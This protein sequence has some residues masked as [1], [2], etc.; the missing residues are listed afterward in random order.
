LLTGGAGFIGLHMCRR[1]LADGWDVVVV[2]NLSRHGADDDLAALLPHV[3]LV[4]HDLT[5]GLPP[6]VTGHFDAVLHLAAWVG[7]DRV[8]R[9][10][11]RV[12]RDNVVATAAVL[13][14]CAERPVDTVFLSSTS[15]VA[16]GAAALGLAGFPIGEDAPFAL[17]RPHAARTTYA[18]SKLVGE[19]LLLHRAGARVRIGRYYNVYGP[20]MGSNHVIPQFIERAVEGTDPFP[21]YGGTNRRAFCHVSDAVEA[22][23]RLVELPGDEPVIANIG[24]DRAELSMVELAGLVNRI[25][26][27]APRIEVHAAPPG[28]PE[29]RVPDLTRL[30]ALT[31]YESRTALADGVAETYQW[32]AERA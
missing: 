7:V 22:T 20:R 10:P 30:R 1:L 32:Y 31:G 2:D 19:S 25:A 8:G 4:E 12:L 23:V 5:A 9:E 27:T 26:G 29:R 14:W 15:E 13:D 16:D 24:D 17:A 3:H 28:S 11:F 21:V 6:G 18:L